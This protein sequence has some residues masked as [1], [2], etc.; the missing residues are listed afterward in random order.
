MKKIAKR[1]TFAA[2]AWRNRRIAL[3][4]AGLALVAAPAFAADPNAPVITG[5]PDSKAHEVG[6]VVVNGVPYRET[7]LPTRLSS[8]SVYGINLNVMD[9]P[10]NT[11]LISTTQL[12]SLNIQDPR[13]FSYLTSSAYSDASFGTPNIPRIRG[14]YA[15]AFM[16]GMRDSF[17]QN[18]YGVPINYDAFQNVA[19]TKGPASVIDGP[20][21]NVGGQVDFLTKRP[22]LTHQ[23]ETAD[24]TLDTLGNH[25]W[26]VDVGGPIVSDDLGVLLSYS[27]EDSN[28][29]YFSGHY[30]YKEALYGAVRWQ[31]NDK[32]RLDVNAE[33]NIQRYTEEVGVNRVNQALINNGSY[34]QG[35]PVGQLDTQIEF[36]GPFAVNPPGGPS[37]PYAAVPFLTEV[38]LANNG[39]HLN[40][41]T[42][43]DETPGVGSRAN[44]F[45]FQAIQTYDFNSNLKLENNTLFMYQDSANYEPYYYADTSNGS[46]SFENRLDITGDYPISFGSFSFKNQFVVGATYRYAHTNYV[47]DYSAETVSVYDLTGNPNQWK[48]PNVNQGQLTDD[49]FQYKGPFGVT[50]YGTPG[51]DIVNF[52]NTGIS[53]LFDSGVFFQD[54]MEFSPQFSILFG[55]RLDAL[56]NHSYDPLGG[57]V[58]DACFTTLPGTIDPLPQSH[59]TGVFGL[60]EFNTSLVWR[61]QGWVTGYL[62][63]D[64]TQS[65]DSPNGGEGGIN[66][67]GQLPDSFL[68]R[69]NNFLYE[70]GLKFNLLD[71]RLF[72]GLAVFDQKRRVPTSPTGSAQANIEGVEVEANYQPTRSFYATAS[73]SY[74]KTT[75]ESAPEFY[76]YPAAPGLNVDGGGTFAVFA[77]N[78]TFNDPGVPQHLFNFLGN[79]K[80]SN[81]IGLRTGVQ[82]TGPMATSA[83]GVLDLLASSDG[84]QIPLPTGPGG[85][86]KVS[87]VNPNYGYYTA[88]EIPWQYTWNAAVFYEW[89]RY[90]LTLSVYNLTDQRN[91]QPSPPLYGND[92]LVLSDPRTFELRLQAKF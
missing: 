10:R 12:E 21:P 35:A 38:Q 23:S 92:F 13:A 82:V 66:T 87:T 30:F 85:S 47:S 6:E 9:T 1:T 28:N 77:P 52:G 40:P 69:Q 53:D 84:N 33:A 88:P 45:N 4:A 65:T 64:W 71:N 5:H 20:G 27:G 83:S 54:R 74:I 81:G 80:F 60:G 34:L 75:L 91:W 67:Y 51:R 46:W 58:C 49:S 48:F 56:Q 18:G 2:R 16:N 68:L 32:Y 79:Y 14:Q 89:S 15:D 31:P 73:Y 59:T 17:S 7:V 55:A 63:F 44:L 29:T 3:T 43:L 11:T 90:T 22:S 26:M 39:A 25:R 8:S 70:A 76:D 62:T 72:A 61:P 86:I 37:Q 36:A 41:R 78:Q 50:L 42:T 19:I 24:V 57:A